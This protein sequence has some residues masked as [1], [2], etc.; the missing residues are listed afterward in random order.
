VVYIQIENGDMFGDIDFIAS[1]KEKGIDIKEIIN[2]MF[3]KGTSFVRYFTVVCIK[4]SCLM[5]INI[6][7]LHKMSKLHNLE[8][9]GLFKN[10]Q[11]SLNRAL[12]QKLLLTQNISNKKMMVTASKFYR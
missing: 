3:D 8:F 9:M 11:S 10:S 6:Q 5:S 4:E 1:A 12:K 2:K 7:N